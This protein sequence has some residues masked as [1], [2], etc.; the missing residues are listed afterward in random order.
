MLPFLH[1]TLPQLIEAGGYIGVFAIVFC[2]SGLPFGFI[3]PGD[4]LLFTAG[5]LASEHLIGIVP[6]TLLATLAAILGDSAGYWIG[7]RTGPLLFTKDDSILFKKRYVA[8]AS[9]F[10]EKHGGR[11]LILA[12]FIPAVRTFTPIL[13]GVARMPYATFLRFNIIGG[14]AW[15]A[16][17]TL[18]GYY[19]GRAFPQSEHYLTYIV[20][21]ILVA[22]ALPLAFEFLKHRLKKNA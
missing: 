4:S 17:V 16:G 2:E 21:A 9:E 19:V 20:L 7:A 13:A 6:L 14:L 22:S 10:Y 8:R 15:G 18:L 5:L 1:L 11:A 12:R 3:F